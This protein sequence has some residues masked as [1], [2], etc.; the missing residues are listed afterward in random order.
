MAG[1][2]FCFQVLGEDPLRR[3]AYLL[4]LLPRIF[5]SPRI[6]LALSSGLLIGSSRG[7]AAAGRGHGE[8]HPQ[9][10]T[11]DVDDGLAM[12]RGVLGQA[13]QRVQAPQPHRRL[14]L[15]LSSGVSPG[16]LRA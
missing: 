6:G 16:R 11:D 8:G 15:G 10:G 4:F 9:V 5:A 3:Q 13:L 12:S 7:L 1:R 14:S 2:W